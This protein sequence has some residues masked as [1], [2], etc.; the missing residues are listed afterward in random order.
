MKGLFHD[1]G[2]VLGVRRARWVLLALAASVVGDGAARVGLLLRVH[3]QGGGSP[4]LAVLLVLFALPLVFLAGVAGRL[5]ELSDVRPVVLAAAATQLLAA[6][7]LAWRENLV[8]TGGAVLVLQCGFA[9]ANPAWVVALPRLVP[10]KRVGTLVSLHHG[11]LAIAA[12]TG[13]AAGGLLMEYAGGW[14][15]FALDALSCI[16][17]ILAG[18]LL[19]GEGGEQPG[20][21]AGRG[22]L[23]TL[24]PL[25]GVAA[26]RAQPV[27]A[28]LTF[29]VLPFV[30][31]L[32]SVNA[33]EVFLVRDVLGGSAAAFGLS[34][35]VAGA[36]AVVGALWAGAARVLHARVTGILV[37]L[38]GV[39]A[40]QLAQG[41]APTMAVYVTLAASVGLLMGRLNAL[42]M[43]LMV[44]ATDPATRGRV[45]AFVGGAARS[46]TVLAMALGGVLGTFLGP[47]ASFIVVGVVGLGICGWATRA[48]RLELAR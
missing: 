31:V 25:D 3:E 48:V 32:E 23:R 45:V 15:P 29:A 36:A 2:A 19:T 42:I 8:W 35:G 20:G 37:A 39:A 18:L 47:R 33:V 41:L 9:L 26:L 14:S 28:T 11:V 46:C 17:L 30:V 34:E 40:A 27:L 43:T 16:P 12:P 4:T 21:A 22:V 10:E 24:L 44:T 6:L 1:I 5:A 13:A 38:G 7:A